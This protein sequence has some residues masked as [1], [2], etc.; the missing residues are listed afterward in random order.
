MTKDDTKQALLSAA[1]KLFTEKAY[2]AVSTRELA[3][4]A[5]VNLGAIQYHFGSKAKLFVETVHSM[6]GGGACAQAGRELSGGAKTKE[7]AAQKI[8][9]Y[10]HEFVR[11]MLCPCGLP[12]FRLVFREVFSD[13]TRDKEMFDALVDSTVENYIRP[14]VSDLVN[15]IR[16]LLPDADEKTLRRTAASIAGQCSFYG[17][18]QPFMERLDGRSYND[19]QICKEKSEHIARFT[20]QALGCSKDFIEKALA[21]SIEKNQ[22]K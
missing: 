1:E 22:R 5:G 8:C 14:V 9:S 10:V 7:E 2:E 20:L 16:I 13:T 12:A 6:M 15:V 4:A 11:N 19:E 17:T 21:N 18:H 3:E